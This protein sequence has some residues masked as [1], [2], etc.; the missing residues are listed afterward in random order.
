MFHSTFS[1]FMEHDTAANGSVSQLYGTF[2]LFQSQTALENL[3]KKAPCF[4]IFSQ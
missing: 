2:D 1:T 4:S 3:N